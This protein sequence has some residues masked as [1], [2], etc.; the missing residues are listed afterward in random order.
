MGLSYW[1]DAM[2]ADPQ[3]VTINSV[4]QSL[5]R[6]G[7]GLNAGLFQKDDESYK[8]AINHAKGNRNRRVIR[9]DNY[10]VATDPLVPATN[11]PF[12]A[13]VWLAVDVPKVGYTIAEQALLTNGFLAYLSASSYAVMTKFLGGES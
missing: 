9:L 5:A 3:S 1:S 12:R 10:K 2:F 13:A 6:I 8:L 4:A 7:Q 11:A